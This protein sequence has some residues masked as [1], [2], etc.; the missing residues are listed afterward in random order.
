[1]VEFE[2]LMKILK[3]IKESNEFFQKTMIG[4][5]EDLN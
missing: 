2:K 5:D 1:M 4:R 3:Y